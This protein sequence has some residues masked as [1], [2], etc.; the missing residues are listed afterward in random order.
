MQL[1]GLLIR[2]Y[3]LGA[4]AAM[5]LLA[6][7]PADAYAECGLPTPDYS[8]E[9]VVDVSG[10]VVRMR[11]HVS[12]RKLREEADLGQGERVTIRRPGQ[13]SIVFDPATRRGTVLPE[14]QGPRLPSRHQDEIPDGA[15]TRIVQV[16]KNGR[17][18]DL[19]RTTCRSDGIIVKQSFVSLDPQGREVTG[20]VTQDNIY[21]A[22]QPHA[23]F[24]LPSGL[25][26]SG[27]SSSPG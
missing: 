20:T 4:V 8:A 18:L 23:L 22:P 14:P 9:R 3:S 11:V 2:A 15:P 17:W 12:D 27:S 6:V 13:R 7:S 25:H 21:V 26:L 19:S 10:H 5:L 1:P 16:E 24:E